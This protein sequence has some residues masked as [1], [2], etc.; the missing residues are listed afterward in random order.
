MGLSLKCGSALAASVLAF[1]LATNAG[2]ASPEERFREA[3]ALARAGDYPGAVT[4][5]R[6]LAEAGVESASLY[7]NWG[8]AAQAR[9]ATGEALWA[10]MRAREI[11]PGERALARPIDQLRAAANLDAAEIAPEPLQAVAR[12][13]RR[14]RLDWAALALLAL[15][16]AAQAVAR[17]R[18]FARGVTAVAW[19]ALALGIT[20]AL[21]PLL[22]AWARPTA[23]VVTRAAPLLDAAASAATAVGALREGEVVPI[24]ERGA[25]FVR[26]EDS[27]GARGWAHVDDVRPLQGALRGTPTD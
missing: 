16:L 6:E 21:V 14:L 19:G 18:P 25:D 3:S 13:A 11:D 7:W 26:I 2:A 22:G 17:A 24:L 9:G 10:L 8:Q 5:Y 1:S 27:A 23:V 15:S 4:V 20:L 12:V